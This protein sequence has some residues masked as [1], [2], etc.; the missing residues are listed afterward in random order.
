MI[1]LHKPKHITYRTMAIKT[2]QLYSITITI[3]IISLFHLDINLM[4][5]IG[6][7]I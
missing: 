4:K 5:Q 1:L 2:I 6:V 3:I 7:E